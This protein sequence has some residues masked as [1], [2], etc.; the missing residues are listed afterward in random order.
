MKFLSKEE[1]EK[2]P[3]KRLL[4]YKAKLLTVND[5]FCWCG[6]RSC[7]IEKQDPNRFNKS[8]PTWQ[9]LYNNVKSVLNTREHIERE[10]K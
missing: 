3:T 2:L 1:M 7:D 5:D 10:T 4:A 9:E 8:H 6:D